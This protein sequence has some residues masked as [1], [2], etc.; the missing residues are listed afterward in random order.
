M[1]IYDRGVTFLTDFQFE[2]F[3]DGSLLITFGHDLSLIILIRVFVFD[4]SFKL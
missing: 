1:L 2:A 3:S 4:S